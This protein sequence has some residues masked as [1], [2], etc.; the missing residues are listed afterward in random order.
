[1]SSSTLDFECALI[2]GGAGGLVS[3]SWLLACQ[4]ERPADIR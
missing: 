3:E 1:M 4:G 2:T